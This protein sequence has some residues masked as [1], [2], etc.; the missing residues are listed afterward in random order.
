MTDFAKWQNDNAR[1]LA[2]A[3]AW[4]RA[5]LEQRAGSE[6]DSTLVRPPAPPPQEK[7]KSR[8]RLFG[9]RAQT[10]PNESGVTD[11]KTVAD[12]SGDLV[13]ADSTMDP[14]P[15]LVLL[16][17]RLGLSH[18][19]QKI[20]LLC[21]A[22]EL[23][24]GIGVLCARAQQEPSRPYPTFALAL[25]LFS[26]SAWDALSPERPLRYWQ[27]VE[28]NQPRAQP[29]TTSP[30]RADE[31]M[32]AYLKGLNYLD[33]RLAA[34]LAPVEMPEQ[35]IHLPA[36]Q[37]SSVELILRQLKQ[38]TEHQ[39]APII[40]LLGPDGPSKRLVASHAANALGLRAYQLPVALLPGQAEIETLARLWQRESLLMPIA[41]YLDASGTEGDAG[42][43]VQALT[44]L[45][46]R[47]YGVVFLDTYGVWPDLRNPSLPVEVAKPAPSEQ[48]AVW[49]AALGPKAA[50]TPGLLAGQFNL[51]IAR[52]GHIAASVLSEPVDGHNSL[53]DRLWDACLAATRPRIENLAQR[54]EPKASWDD[55]VLPPAE[56][57]LLRQIADQV[58]QRST[59]YESWGFGHKMSRGLGISVLFSGESGCGKTMAAE[60]LANHLRLNLY[61]VD[62]SAVASKYI[63]ETAKNLRR[64]FDAAEDGGAILFF[65]EADALFGK[66][67]EV[68]D[69]HDRYA[70]TEIDYLLQRMEAYR[71]LAILATNM[72]S[73]LDTA[74]MRRLRFVVNFPYPATA[75]RKDIWKKVF[76]AETPTQGLDF[77]RLARLNLTGGHIHNI[78][79]NAAFLAAKGEPG[80]AITMPLVLAAARTEFRKLDRTINEA[81]FRWTDVPGVAA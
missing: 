47:L 79:L 7:P 42:H 45:L 29:L 22:M 61:R 41:L 48:Q 35:G 23:D 70:N 15:A 43:G 49:M 27:L 6:R 60:V 33:D 3:V 19:E 13:L 75:E 66:R 32:V 52:I 40:Q 46:E 37:R 77:D 55:I 81:D 51:D 9:R 16:G 76:P 5:L 78:A 39:R 18:F 74:F 17:Q 67:S 12:F 56:K 31:R 14:P 65:D 36:S 62:L 10:A 24:A 59:V 44:R 30:L 26:D 53:Q 64:L 25:T 20:L 34:L 8:W 11:R 28:I 69:A 73:A 1:Y 21:A 50:E 38:T 2:N 68:K 72:K 80:T 4:L 58:A 71:G 57:T 54:I 63:G